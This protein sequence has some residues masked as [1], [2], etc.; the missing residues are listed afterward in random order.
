MLQYLGDPVVDLRVTLNWLDA[1]L[2]PSADKISFWLYNY[3]YL[4]Y[5]VADY[6]GEKRPKFFPE[7]I[8][9]KFRPYFAADRN[10]YSQRQYLG[11]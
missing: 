5:K 3:F 7:S 2:N 10:L 9:R 4:L 11:N 1:L 6:S 8:C